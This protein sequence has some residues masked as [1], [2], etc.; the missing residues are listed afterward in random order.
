[1][2]H[3]EPHSVGGEVIDRDAEAEA[4]APQCSLQNG[5]VLHTAARLL[6]RGK[7]ARISAEELG[8]QIIQMIEAE[9]ARI[10]EQQDQDAGS[11]LQRSRTANGGE[12]PVW[13]FRTD[14]PPS[15]PVTAIMENIR[16]WQITFADSLTLF[17]EEMRNHMANIPVDQFIAHASFR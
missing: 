1:M 2:G 15:S 4:D 14:P 7:E 12:A 17:T 6:P 3:L 16:R 11:P 8:E 5:C 13:L 10:A 9:D